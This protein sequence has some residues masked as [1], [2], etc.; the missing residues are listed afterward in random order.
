MFD[1]FG[2]AKIKRK[3]LNRKIL[4]INKDRARKK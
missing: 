2:N 4:N 3:V 1:M